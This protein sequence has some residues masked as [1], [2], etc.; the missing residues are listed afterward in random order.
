MNE[1][2]KKLDMALSLIKFEVG[3]AGL[4]FLS[5]VTRSQILKACKGAGLMFVSH[6]T[7]LGEFS[8]MEEID[9]E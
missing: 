5:P 7:N 1:L 9:C 2:T 6:D 8:P 3:D 4:Q